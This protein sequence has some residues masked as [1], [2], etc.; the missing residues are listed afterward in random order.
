M[1]I[2]KSRKSNGMIKTAKTRKNQS[3]WRKEELQAL[4]NTGRGY[5]QP[6]ENE[7]KNTNRIPQTNEK[8]SPNEQ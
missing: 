1:L 6:S 5:N 8:P 3:L 4:G 2:M 7:R